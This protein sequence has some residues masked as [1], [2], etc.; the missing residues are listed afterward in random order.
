MDALF[1]DD[2]VAV[3]GAAALS[4]AGGFEFH[5]EPWPILLSAP[6]RFCAEL[7]E[8]LLIGRAAA[9]RDAC[10]ENSCAWTR[11]ARKAG[12]SVAF[13]PAVAAVVDGRASRRNGGGNL[14][15]ALLQHAI[16]KRRRTD[17]LTD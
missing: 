9:R 7:E 4:L 1:N 17:K 5:F 14:A 10:S 2:A 13:A 11:G 15:A 16:M 6:L 8:V 12:G 3:P